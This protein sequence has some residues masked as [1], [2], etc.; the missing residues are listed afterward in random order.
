M[1]LGSNGGIA[2]ALVVAERHGF[3][4]AYLDAYPKRIAAITTTDVN[5]ALKRHFFADR[6]NVIVAGD[7]DKVPD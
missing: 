4:P 7:V 5:A 3:G 1:N 6:L 2:D